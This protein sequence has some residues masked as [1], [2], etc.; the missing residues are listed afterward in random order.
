[1]LGHATAAAFYAHVIDRETRR[2]LVYFGSKI[3]VNAIPIV[4]VFVVLR[5]PL[6]RPMVTRRVILAGVVTGL[7]M[8]VGITAIYHAV[9]SGRIEAGAMLAKARAYGAVDHFYL[10]ATFLCV[11]NSAMEEY[12]WRWFV[13]R[14]L[15]QFMPIAPAVVLSAIGFTL[16]HVVVL[17]AYF[18][19]AGLVALLNIGVF[20]G[21][22]VWAVLY[23][24]IRSLLSPWISH[25]LVDA[26][27]MAVAYAL[28][29][30]A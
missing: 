23:E 30:P 3:V 4:W 21:G 2:T 7:A 18:P 11:G 12:Y 16:H 1:M 27:I 29:F 6:R 14:G 8:G 17:S 26:A 9:F 19:S 5:Q 15:R 25:A 13:Y 28:L 24:R 22:C 10:F 20:A